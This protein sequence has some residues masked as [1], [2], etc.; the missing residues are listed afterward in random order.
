M[1]DW[2]LLAV[3]LTFYTMFCI[4]MAFIVCMVLVHLCNIAWI[5]MRK[6]FPNLPED[7]EEYYEQVLEEGRSARSKLLGISD[8]DEHQIH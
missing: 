6:I 8:R 5:L 7:R 3:F 1:P 2:F 4:G